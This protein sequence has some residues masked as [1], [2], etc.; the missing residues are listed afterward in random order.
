MGGFELRP[1]QKECVQRI[2]QGN[3]IVNMP[4]GT[5]KT[6][7]AVKAIDHFRKTGK[8]LF[9]VPTRALV[10]QQA[11]YVRD[12]AAEPILVKELSGAATD[13][14]SGEDWKKAV[15]NNDVLVG[16][17]EVFRKAI[18]DS[19]HVKV[20]DF[21]LIIFDECHNTTGNSPMAAMCRDALHRRECGPHI[22]GLTASFV[23][24]GLKGIDQKRQDI[25]GLLQ[26]Q[27]FC[28]EV[29]ER[30]MEFHRITYD[31]DFS[32]D[33][34]EMVRNSTQVLIKLLEEAG[35]P[36]KEANKAVSR[37]VHVFGE[38]GREA[39]LYYLEECVA[40]QVRE[41]LRNL[42]E[43]QGS[44]RLAD[45]AAAIDKLSERLKAV[46]QRLGESELEELPGVTD[47][48]KTLIDLLRK[49]QWD[50]QGNSRKIIIF[51]EQTV[52][53]FPL[54]YILERDLRTKVSVVTGVGSMTDGVRKE[55]LQSFKSGEKPIMAC[56]AA[57]EEGLDVSECQVVIRFS[58]F[59]TTKSHVQG[60]GRARKWGAHVY[61]FDNDPD[62]EIG[63]AQLMEATARNTALTLNGHDM[64]ARKTHKDVQD[65]H[66]YRTSSGVEI[67]IF[68]G[69]E[70][71]YQYAQKV[72]GQSFR[73]EETMLHYEKE[74]V[75]RHPLEERNR[76]V[77]VTV[78]SPDGYFHVHAKEVDKFW[79]DIGLDDIAEPSRMKNWNG[80]KKEQRRF[81][82]VVAV[83]LSQKGYINENNEPTAKALRETR[84]ACEAMTMS[85]GIKIGAKYG[86]PGAS[87]SSSSAIPA[88]T[89]NYKGMLNELMVATPVTYSTETRTG[90]DRQPQFLSFVK[91]QDG[92]SF[93]GP[94]PA[95]N[96][97]ASEQ[98]AAEVAYKALRGSST[99]SP[100]STAPFP[101][102]SASTSSASTSSPSPST[103]T[104]SPNSTS[105]NHKGR[106]NELTT[107]AV[108]Y[109]TTRSGSNNFVSTVTL[110]NGH[111]V[112][113]PKSASNKKEA[114]QIAAE[115]A[116]RYLGEH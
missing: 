50:D 11:Q 64:A 71:V 70:L 17:A 94:G 109:D 108:K 61:Y 96:K 88:P 36:V 8:A 97:K 86:T 98:L 91:F 26:A 95:A 29:E 66:P 53:A 48:A 20:S 57:L 12:N 14:M 41:H 80:N 68:S 116:L 37:A 76:L 85:A 73:P 49:I 21:S 9:L 101:Q 60:A 46:S 83:K 113:G 2:L 52:L 56:T 15:V 10:S 5:G 87:T 40:P 25:E 81:L 31:V 34:E 75:C 79:G 107:G 28:P 112:K 89:E 6:L 100:L 35:L 23:N 45:S 27:I 47:K 39:F 69:I 74:V 4:T 38:L 93:Q 59:K 90:S 77:R 114:E 111:L 102:S 13:N 3:T 16:T 19:K 63:G 99:F 58:A 104:P 72:M 62:R 32:Q 105:V 43:V 55:A 67:L 110:P 82:Y 22:L 42:D 24:G 103:P 84:H 1:Y 65:V 115:A 92:R 78:P 33:D 106:L 44:H 51:T 7:V 18:V 54:G 30:A